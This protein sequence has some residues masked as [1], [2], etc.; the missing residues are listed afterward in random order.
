MQHGKIE[1]KMIFVI[2]VIVISW[3]L[4]SCVAQSRASVPESSVRQTQVITETKKPQGWKIKTASSVY[5]MAVA[6]DGIVIPVYYGPRGAPL[7]VS[8]ANVHVSP[9]VGSLIREVPFRGGFIAQTPSVEVIFPDRTRECDLVYSSSQILEIEGFPCLRIDLGDSAYGLTVSSYIRVIPELDILEKWLVLKNKEKDPILIENAQSGS[10]WLPA[11]EYDLFHLSGRW[12]NEFMLQRTR[13][14]PGVKT[15]QTRAFVAHENPP[16]FTVTPAKQGSETQGPVW[17]GG[18]HWSGNWRFDFEKFPSGNVQIIGGIN[19]WDT[20]WQLKPAE[21][22]STPKLVLGFSPEGMSG[23]SARMHNY[24]RN[25]VLRKKFRDALRPVLYNSWYATTFNVNEQQQLALARIAREIGVELFVID[26]GWFKGRNHDRAGLGDWTV[27]KKKFPNGLQPLIKKI[28]D[29]GLD[30]G[31]WV[32][33]EM[34]NPDSDLYRAHPDWV[35]HYPKRTRHEQRNQLVLNLAGEGVYNYL[36]ESLSTLL[37]ENN[38]RFIK[39][40]RN[41][42]LSDVGW[43]DAPVPMQREVRIRFINNLYNLIDE[44]QTR[45]PEV[46][47]ESCSGG[48]GRTDLGIIS[49]MDQVWTSD[50]T[51]PADRVM[52]Q[53]GYSHAFP[54]KLMVSWVTNADWHKVSPSLKFRFH[55]CMS[56][57]L[58]I[59]TDLTKW[60]EEERKLAA[61]MIALYK[62][63]RPLVQEGILHRLH[64]PFEGNRAALQYVSPDGSEAVV[65]LYNLWETL[66]GSTRTARASGAVKL[67]GLDPDANYLLSG[68][69]R[70]TASGETLMNIGLPWFVRGNFNSAIVTLKKQTQ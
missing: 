48:G 64:S 19:F 35:L 21:E 43:P 58:G 44:L 23:A 26:D 36:L 62:K 42:A 10:A 12:G 17:F 61:D 24:I 63:I 45:F 39:W 29:L 69:R 70:G 52:I 33:P 67:T 37:R 47:F 53:Y 60:S 1:Y 49:R 11:D 20:A 7:Q 22:F 15:I 4:N 46:L 6:R 50:N 40:D 13:L 56:G 65:F 54:A 32:E 28:S 9:K 27:D 18:L 5:Q 51:D 66:P 57:V 59:G 25:H 41:R 55:V 34:V 38:I 8:R 68:D 2:A 16:W 30:F 3:S 14:T 31:I